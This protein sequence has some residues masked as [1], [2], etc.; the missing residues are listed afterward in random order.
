[1]FRFF[2]QLRKDL[3]EKG[4]VR[5]YSA[6]AVGEIVLVV[7]GIL[8]ALQINNANEAR[9]ENQRETRYL[10]NLR[11]DLESNIEELERVLELRR[12][13]I[14]SAQRVLEYFEGKP[15]DDLADFN[16]HNI[17]VHLWQKYYQNNNTFQQ[18]VNSGNLAII[19]NESIKNELMNLELLY[20]KMKSDE[21]HTR[22]D[23]EGYVFKPFFD[24]VDIGPMTEN[25]AYTVSNGLAGSQAELSR[26]DIE[27]LLLDVKYKNG[28][29]LS[30]Y[31]HTQ[32][33]IE[34]E[35]IKLRTA[36]LVDLIARELADQ[37]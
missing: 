23:F 13:R 18:L 20:K 2:R 10:A 16:Y 1:M 9:L 31:M 14:V 37:H 34:L 21:D 24:A 26:D 32:I 22:Y 11:V 3:L 25:Y 27:R 5:R 15:L 33:N 7:I 28:F 8:I 6:Y 19:R 4:K 35:E 17:H 29:T 36:E 12:S 30:I